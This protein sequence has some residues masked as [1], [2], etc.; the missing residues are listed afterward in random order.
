MKKKNDK[1]V[2][3]KNE[4]FPT[5]IQTKKKKNVPSKKNEVDEVDSKKPLKKPE[6]LEK[7]TSKS[8][9]TKTVEK[10]EIQKPVIEQ[11]EIQKPV[12]QKQ[13][14]QTNKSSVLIKNKRKI[15]DDDEEDDVAPTKEKIA[16][17]E[18]RNGF[19]C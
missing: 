11:Q 18:N 6:T 9:S 5:S 4:N 2:I 12:A 14:I 16:R 7:T 3:Q 15:L 19:R 13:E 17:K 8:S 10:E 1:I